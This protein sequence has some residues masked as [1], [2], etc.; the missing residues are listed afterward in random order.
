MAR[1]VLQE[2][3]KIDPTDPLSIASWLD[4]MA[5]AGKTVVDVGSLFNC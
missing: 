4:E 1:E 2:V 3:L 5:T